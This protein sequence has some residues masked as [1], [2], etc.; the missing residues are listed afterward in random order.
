[1]LS[2]AVGRGLVSSNPAKGVHP[3][4]GSPKERFLTESEVKLIADALDALEREAEIPAVASTA[5]KLLLLT[6]CRKG[7]ILSL[8]WHYVDFDHQCL[9]LPDS[10]TGAK[11]IPVAAAA[12][13]ILSGLSR[14]TM[15]VLPA[16]KGQGHYV[17]LQKHWKAVKLKASTLALEVSG[18]G[19]QS[20]T[21]TPHFDNVRL[22]DLRHS[23]ASFAVMDGAAL[24]LV[25]KLLGH[26]QTRTTEIYAHVADHP[27]RATAEIATRR[28][29]RAMAPATVSKSEH[30]I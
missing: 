3:Y 25:G 29:A 27:L 22:H 16:T 15:W 24:Y 10:K 18:C 2:F 30:E 5:I 6:G 7:E 23:F 11:I 19:D 1:M 28:I 21:D 26:K 8:R 4:R 20:P 17:G 13:A 12:L 9:R 14:T